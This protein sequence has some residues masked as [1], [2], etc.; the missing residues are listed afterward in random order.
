MET[1]T[2]EQVDAASTTPPSDKAAA[3]RSLPDP[4]GLKIQERDIWLLETVAK[5]KM[6]TADQVAVVCGFESAKQARKRLER[7]VKADYVQK[8]DNVFEQKRIYA[9]TRLG[10]KLAQSESEYDLDHIKP[11][12]EMDGKMSHLH[13][14]N[15]TRLALACQLP[16]AGGY[17]SWWQT[18]WELDDGSKSLVPDALLQIDWQGESERVYALEVE[19]ATRAPKGFLN[20][21]LDYSAYKQQHQSL[22]GY[23]DFSLLVLCEGEDRC[24]RYRQT[25]HALSDRSW[26][27]FTTCE[28]IA[29]SGGHEP[30]WKAAD[31]GQCYPLYDLAT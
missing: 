27:W 21:I 12:R 3:A 18:D 19:L 22:Y 10:L 14:I 2:P 5:L 16:N 29:Q 17:L 25:P 11:P 20:K 30:I 4:P 23:P 24:E 13:A 9:I 8:F 15:S 26:I 7:F 6:A 28:A 1:N 31:D